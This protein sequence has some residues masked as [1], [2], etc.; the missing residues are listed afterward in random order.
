[1]KIKKSKLSNGTQ[2]ILVDLPDST[3]VSAIIFAKVGSRNES[4]ETAG[5]SHFTEHCLFKGSKK[6]PSAKDLSFGF[7]ELGAGIDAGTSKE[8]TYFMI[9]ALKENASEVIHILTDLYMNPLFPEDEI[10]RERNVVLEEIRMY[11]DNP[12]DGIVRLF[13]K[14][15]WKDQP[16]G[17]SISGTISSVRSLGREDLQKHVQKYYQSG[18]TQIVIAG[19]IARIGDAISRL[20]IDMSSLPEGKMKSPTKAK[21][22]LDENRVI[23]KEEDVEQA[24]LILGCYGVN[25]NDDDKFASAVGN[26]ILGQ[27]MGSKLYESLR[28]RQGLAYYVNSGNIS[29]T[30]SGSMYIR[31]GVDHRRVEKAVL[32]MKE[33]INNVIGGYFSEKEVHRAKQ[34]LKSAL[35]LELDSSDSLGLY[36]GHQELLI[37][38]PLSLEEIKNK[39][40]G[41]TREDITNI[42]K[43]KFGGPKLFTMISPKCVNDRPIEDII[44]EIGA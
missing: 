17:R 10:L 4:K 36:I 26:T 5:I 33:E 9:K 21:E 13:S 16:V 14:N 41:I 7:E 18:N 23:C 35:V 15:M 24:H 20:E 3:S 25:L 11:K 6:Y 40:D 29:Y 28:H 30:D 34:L 27:G 1:M 31:A 42:F 44:E 38:D 37:D 32:A 43:S 12:M 2:L 39:V 22:N 19:D 8:Y